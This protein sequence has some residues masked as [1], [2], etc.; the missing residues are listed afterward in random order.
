MAVAKNHKDKML[1]FV[2]CLFFGW[3]FVPYFIATYKKHKN[4]QSI[5]WV[6]F[7]FGWTILA[8]II[9]LALALGN[10]DE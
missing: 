6:N 1:I 5:F 2:L 8:W 7:L 4:A 10:P 9:A 3:Y